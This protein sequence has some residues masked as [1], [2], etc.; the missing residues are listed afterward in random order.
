MF[1]AVKG[2]HA[3]GH[4]FVAKAIERGAAAIVVEHEVEASVPQVVVSSTQVALGILVA[5]SLGDPGKAMTLVG[6][7]GTNG[8]TT[9]TYLVEAI[10][11]AAGKRVGVIGTVEMRYGDTVVPATTRRRHPRSCTARSRRCATPAAR[12][13]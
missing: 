13:S 8:K 10:L 5:R 12:T 9:T 1:V 11:R 6:V 2:L 7:T 4:A 3:D